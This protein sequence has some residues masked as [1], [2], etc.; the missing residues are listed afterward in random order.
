MLLFLP[1]VFLPLVFLPLAFL[2]LATGDGLGT[3]K[4]KSIENNS[5]DSMD[6]VISKTRNDELDHSEEKKLRR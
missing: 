6:D 2:P 3:S 4:D 1:L 5:R